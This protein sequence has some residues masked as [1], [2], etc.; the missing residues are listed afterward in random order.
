MSII[1]RT[2]YTYWNDGLCFGGGLLEYD[3]VKEAIDDL[4][5]I[6]WHNATDEIIN[7]EQTIPDGHA[8]EIQLGIQQYV[9]VKRHAEQLKRATAQ[10]K[11]HQK[12]LETVDDEIKR[13]SIRV[14]ELEAEIAELN[15]ETA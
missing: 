15:K 1:V 13:R 12:W 4:K 5:V 10:L 8:E 7:I 2:H 6:A 3:S 14:I 9:K 11:D